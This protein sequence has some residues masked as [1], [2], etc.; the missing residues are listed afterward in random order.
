[1]KQRFI[2]KYQ[3]PFGPLVTGIR[4][5]NAKYIPEEYSNKEQEYK[6]IKDLEDLG[7]SSEEEFAKGIEGLEEYNPN[8]PE[9][10]SET[11][12]YG[13][14]MVN[15]IHVPNYIGGSKNEVR[16]KYFKQNPDL[17][18]YIKQISNIYGI[19]PELLANRLAHEGFI[20]EKIKYNNWAIRVPQF[21]NLKGLQNIYYWDR[22]T[23]YIGAKASGFGQFGLDF[24]G[25]LIRK[26]KIKLLNNEQYDIG[27]GLTYVN[28]HGVPVISAEGKSVR[29]NISLMGAQL[30]YNFEQASKDFPE[31]DKQDLNRYASIYYNRGDSNGRKYIQNNQDTSE[32]EFIPELSALFQLK[33]GAIKQRFK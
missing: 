5:E 16:V 31:A 17:I 26:G 10:F 25:D 13:R 21:Y 4:E 28:E 30:R 23:G 20:D 15:G 29:D 9:G 33:G 12:W 18:N 27:E 8:N 1:M 7:F 22:P 3:K 2:P 11:E 32:Y 24:T 6:R 14:Q 19:S